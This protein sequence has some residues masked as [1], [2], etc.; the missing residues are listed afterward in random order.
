MAVEDGRF[1]WIKHIYEYRKLIKVPSV[2]R[3]LTVED[4]VY[5]HKKRLSFN[6]KKQCAKNALCFF[7]FG[8]YLKFQKNQLQTAKSFHCR[9]RIVSNYR[10]VNNCILFF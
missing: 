8:N 9:L 5:N 7:L 1:V 6:I 4:E 10:I 2:R 3:F